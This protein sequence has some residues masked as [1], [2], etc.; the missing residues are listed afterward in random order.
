M[1]KTIFLL[2]CLCEL[3]F[4][5]ENLVIKNSKYSVSQTIQNVKEIALK[6]G[7]G[8]YAIINYS[9][10]AAMLGQKLQEAKLIIFSNPKIDTQLIKQNLFTSLDLPMK[11]LVYRKSSTEVNLAYKNLLWL[12]ETYK[13]KDEKALNQA[14]IMLK[15]IT[16]KAIK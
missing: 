8:V 12:K 6:N 16:N 2:L 3:A 13:L 4:S 11:I 1:K 14:N 10:N 5:S 9:G 15:K 7:L